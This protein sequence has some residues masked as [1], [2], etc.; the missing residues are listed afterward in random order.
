VAW[1][2]VKVVQA[3]VR[4]AQAGDKRATRAVKVVRVVGRR[5]AKAVPAAVKEA[6][7]A[8]RAAQVVDKAAAAADRAG[9]VEGRKVAVPAGV[10]AAQALGSL[11][12]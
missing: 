9:R 11:S 7:A 3:A 2:I 4:V 10:R 5:V 8:V 1:L 12:L 6:P